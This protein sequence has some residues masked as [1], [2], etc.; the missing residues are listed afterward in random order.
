M[1]ALQVAAFSGPEAVVVAD[2]PDPSVSHALA[3]GDPIVIEVR[4]AGVTFADVLLSR[5]VY[6]LRP[7]LPFVP[8][9]EVAGIVRAAPE[10]SELGP[11]EPVA[12]FTQLGGFAKVAVAPTHLTFRL[13]EALDFAQGAGLVLNYHTAVFALVTRGR[14]SAGEHVL[15]H[16]GTGGLGTVAL[17]VPADSA[18]ARSRSCPPT[19]RRRWR[20]GP[21]RTRSC[22]PTAS[23]AMRCASS[24][25]RAVDVVLDP[26]GG[27]RFTDSR[28]AL[29]S[30]GRVVVVGF[31]DGSI[32]QVKVNRLLLHN[33]QVVGAAWREWVIHRPE[34]GREIGEIVIASGRRRRDPPARGRAIP[35]GR[36]C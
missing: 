12:A 26:V 8:G 6:Q 16:G 19:R 35:A 1:R 23:G 27:E 7:E 32:A 3:R 17:Q 21:G 13:P 10:G 18:R 11:G 15:V 2:L 25:A 22:A 4:A 33:T 34:T 9:M 31:T 29:R 14:L 5:G 28:R 20:A 24:R 36:R 30:G